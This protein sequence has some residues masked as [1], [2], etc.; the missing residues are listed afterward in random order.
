MKPF[1]YLHHM[2]LSLQHVT[3]CSGLFSIWLPPVLVAARGTFPVVKTSLAPGLSSC[4]SLAPK[5]VEKLLSSLGNVISL[6]EG[7]QAAAE[8]ATNP[9]LFP[10]DGAVS[11]L[12]LVGVVGRQREGAGWGCTGGLTANP[13]ACSSR[14]RYGVPSGLWDSSAHKVLGSPGSLHI[15]LCSPQGWCKSGGMLAAE[16]PVLS[17]PCPG[18]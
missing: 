10:I 15:I 9:R 18:T 1:T 5:H 11:V 8:S 2:D 16:P 13:A 12:C 7:K 3:L 6:G 14:M 4:S 17:S